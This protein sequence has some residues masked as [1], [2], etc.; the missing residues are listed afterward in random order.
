MSYRTVPSTLAAQNAS[1][2]RQLF[3]DDGVSARTGTAG[4]GFVPIQAVA[5]FVGITSLLDQFFPTDEQDAQ[6]EIEKYQDATQGP[7]PAVDPTIWWPL[8]GLLAMTGAWYYL[9]HKK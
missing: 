4:F 7:G 8:A 3:R 2:R 6:R 1:L 5:P 9:S